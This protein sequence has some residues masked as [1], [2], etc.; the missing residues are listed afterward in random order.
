[1]KHLAIEFLMVIGLAI[2]GS[3]LTTCAREWVSDVQRGLVD[4]Q[5]KGE[6]LVCDNGQEFDISPN[7]GV[8]AN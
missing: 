6:R 8:L 4:C 7:Q 3:A 5:I 2:F 1:M